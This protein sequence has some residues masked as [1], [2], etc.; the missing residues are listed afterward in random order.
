MILYFNTRAEAEAAVVADGGDI[1]TNVSLRFS[2]TPNWVATVGDDRQPPPQIFLSQRDAMSRLTPAEKADIF[3]DVLAAVEQGPDRTGLPPARSPLQ[4]QC[5]LRGQVDYLLP[6]RLGGQ[7][8]P[9]LIR[10][11]LTGQVLR[12][13]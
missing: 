5:G 1:R 3:A 7:T 9:T 4:V 13:S 12:P 6:G 2:Q 8:K 10:D 11:A